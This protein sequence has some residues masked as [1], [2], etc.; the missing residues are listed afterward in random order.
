MKIVSLIQRTIVEIS[1]QDKYNFLQGLVTVDIHK[2]TPDNAL[3]A[4]LLTP[5]GKYLFDFFLY[6]KNDVIFLDI[7]K[8]C[9]SALIEHLKKYI[10][11]ADLTLTLREDIRVIALWDIETI[12]TKEGIIV[13][14][15]R[16]SDMGYRFISPLDASEKF[17]EDYRE[18]IVPIEDYIARRIKNGLVDPATDMKEIDFYPA[19][20][21]AEKFHGIDYKKGCFIGQEVTS[22]LKHKTDLKRSVISVMV[23]GNPEC[24]CPMQTDMKEI[25]TLLCVSGMQGLAYVH[26]ER[27]NDATETLRSVTAGGVY[28]YEDGMMG[29]N[30]LIKL[31]EI[32]L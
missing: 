24:P 2:L 23:L 31:S 1:G 25:G 18:N 22:R 3:W 5:Q 17:I 32:R 6:T 16:I 28:D 10:L 11:R 8:D 15:P 29:Y 27:W 4:G 19:E 13:I 12:L 20:I 30:N 14:D 26:L 21:N 9:A 7:H